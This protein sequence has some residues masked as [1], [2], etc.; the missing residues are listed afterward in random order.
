[1]LNAF[2]ITY[3]VI[4]LRLNNEK[5]IIITDFLVALSVFSVSVTNNEMLKNNSSLYNGLTFR[6]I[7][8]ALMSGRI[9]DI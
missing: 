5:A 9:S 6:S 2:S 8:P 1:M 7:G 3:F 4:I